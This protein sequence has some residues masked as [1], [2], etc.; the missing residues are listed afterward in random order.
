MKELSKSN[1]SAD[2]FHYGQLTINLKG[3]RKSITV[4]RVDGERMYYLEQRDYKGE[5]VQS[6]SYR[7]L[8]KAK[9]AA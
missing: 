9:A 5:L 1:I 7:S 3:S 2:S 4:G 6:N 8:N